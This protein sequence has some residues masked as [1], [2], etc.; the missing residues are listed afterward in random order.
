[1]MR[2]ALL[3]SSVDGFQKGLH[4]GLAF[5]AEF[6]DDDLLHL[7]HGEVAELD[8]LA[9]REGVDLHFLLAK[10]LIGTGFIFHH[11]IGTQMAL[12]ES[13]ARAS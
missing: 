1:M 5:G 4:H 13:T 2:L 12:T 11:K 8:A 9:C 7:R 3:R 10:E 6:L